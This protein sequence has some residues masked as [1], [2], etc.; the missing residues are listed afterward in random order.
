MQTT[1]AITVIQRISDDFT[2]R[3]EPFDD[4][5][6]PE[7]RLLREIESQ[8]PGELNM[9]QR[10]RIVTI[11]CT[12]DYNRD[13]NQLVD[14]L[15]EL[16]GKSPHHFDP[17]SVLDVEELEYLFNGI[18]FRYPNRDAK[19][20]RKNCDILVDKYNGRVTELILASGCD[21]PTLVD[22]LRDDGFLYLKGDKIAPMFAR[23]IS[24]EVA[25][26]DGLWELDIPVDTHIHRL[27]E[28]LAGSDMSNKA[29]RHW[30]R[31]ISDHIDAPRHVVDGGLWH[32]GN[33]WDDWGEEYWEEVTS[34]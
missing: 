31:T 15:V 18:G 29:V 30:W 4:V 5:E 7:T 11:F 25:P 32:I 3:N 23:I 28:E 8:H 24:D 16:D 2:Q 1:N 17:Y 19:G 6:F 21:G 12:L 20:W 22:R 13:A 9:E 33:K 34:V 14:N 26:M 10:A 27:T